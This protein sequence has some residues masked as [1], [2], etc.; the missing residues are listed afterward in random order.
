MTEWWW[1]DMPLSE[2]TND[3]YPIG[4]MFLFF[5]HV[6]SFGC[7]GDYHLEFIVE[8]MYSLERRG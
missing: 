6:L 8:F 4:Q 1:P 7:A 2:W 5:E 3:W